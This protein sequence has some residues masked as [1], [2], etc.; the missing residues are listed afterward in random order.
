MGSGTVYTLYRFGINCNDILTN[1]NITFM[2]SVAFDIIYHNHF[3]YRI[4]FG[5]TPTIYV[6]DPEMIKQITIKDF[7]CFIDHP[8]SKHIFY[9]SVK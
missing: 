6:R 5:R 2:L 9:N 3:Y 7:E 8:V 1:Y 4:Y